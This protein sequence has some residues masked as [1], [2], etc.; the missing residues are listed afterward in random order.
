MNRWE[1][2]RTAENRCVNR[3]KNIFLTTM[4][5]NQEKNE[6]DSFKFNKSLSA[7]PRTFDPSLKECNKGQLESGRARK[8]KK[9]NTCFRTFAALF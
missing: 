2:L 7:F 5:T 9:Q 1:P 3:F 8:D 6:P 4:L